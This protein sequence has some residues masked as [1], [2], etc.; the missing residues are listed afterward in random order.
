MQRKSTSVTDETQAMIGNELVGDHVCKRVEEYNVTVV[1]TESVPYKERENSWCFSMPPRCSQYKVVEREEKR[2]EVLTKTRGVKECCEGYIQL[3]TR[4]VPY[5]ENPCHH[6]TCVATGVCKCDL[7]YGGPACD[8]SCP[9]GQWGKNCILKCNCQNK[10]YCDPYDGKCQCRKGYTGFKCDMPCPEG[11]FGLNCSGICDCKNGAK[12]DALTGECLCINGF[13]GLSC[14]DHCDCNCAPGFIGDDCSEKCPKSYF[15]QD[16]KSKCNCDNGDCSHIDGVCQ[17]LPGWLGESCD[18]TCPATLWGQQCSQKCKC[19]NKS[20]CRNNDGICICNPGFMGQRCDEACP[21]GFY[22]K[23]CIDICKCDQ[24]LNSVCH[25]AHGCVCRLGFTGIN[26]DVPAQDRII[27]HQSDPIKAGVLW[28]LMLSL[29]AMCLIILLIIYYRRRVANLKAEFNHVV[30]YMTEEPAQLNDSYQ[31][32]IQSDY[33]TLLHSNKVMN[34]LRETKP[35]TVHQLNNFNG[36]DS[37]LN[38]QASYNPDY[39]DHKNMEAD[40]TNPDFYHSI[41]DISKDHLYDEINKDVQYDHLDHSPIPRSI[42]YYQR[43][44]STTSTLRQDDHPHSDE[45]QEENYKQLNAYYVECTKFTY[46]NNMKYGNLTF[47]PRNSTHSGEVSYVLT[48]DVKN[49]NLHLIVKQKDPEIILFDKNFNMCII[50]RIRS[51]NIFMKEFFRELLDNLDFEIKCPFKKG[52]YRREANTLYNINSTG[53]SLPKFIT[54]DKEYMVI[55]S[56]GT[57]VNGK[58]EEVIHAEL[59]YRLVL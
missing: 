38:D 34:N 7:K 35:S 52:T 20:Q 22:G 10:G 21:E 43:S 30:K 58:M 54:S 37:N 25:P 28:G 36:D 19:Q 55:H 53:L 13:K 50:A 1:V 46:K 8:I 2:V 59:T 41:E 5:C 31:V 57:R 45:D 3:G 24:K 40:L 27:G 26:C 49:T 48:R 15:G 29:V 6:G 47:G 23:D 4:C 44:C 42:P 33:S 32:S 39:L 14:E 16:C 56:Y 17:C 12:C 18:E 11:Q 51:T 9:P